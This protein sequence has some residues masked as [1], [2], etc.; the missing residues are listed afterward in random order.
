MCC[1]CHS[2]Y[3][4]EGLLTCKFILHA[5]QSDGDVHENLPIVTSYSYPH[6]YLVHKTTLHSSGMRMSIRFLAIGV[7]VLYLELP[8]QA[9][10][11]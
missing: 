3:H 6:K 4:Y 10:E 7:S 9:M 8:G 5:D 1:L 2:L 11:R